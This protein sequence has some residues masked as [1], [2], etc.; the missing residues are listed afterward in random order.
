MKSEQWKV[1]GKLI[2]MTKR[3]HDVLLDSECDIYNG[4]FEAKNWTWNHAF[5]NH[6]VDSADCCNFKGKKWD[7]F[8]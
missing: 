5:K 7:A 4:C 1:G 8:Q 6:N 2:W 3:S